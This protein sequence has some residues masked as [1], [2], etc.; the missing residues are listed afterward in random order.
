[1]HQLRAID[2]LIEDEL[3]VN[4]KAMEGLNLFLVNAS[5]FVCLNH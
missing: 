2:L 5:L 4:K 3:I 1:M